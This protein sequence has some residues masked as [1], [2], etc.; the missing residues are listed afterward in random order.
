MCGPRRTGKPRSFYPLRLLPL[1]PFTLLFVTCFNPSPRLPLRPYLFIY[2]SFLPFSIFRPSVRN[3][4][5]FPAAHETVFSKCRL[6]TVHNDVKSICLIT[7]QELHIGFKFGHSSVIL[8]EETKYTPSHVH[9][10]IIRQLSVRGHDVR[11]YE[12]ISNG[13]MNCNGRPILPPLPH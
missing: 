12:I 3:Q 6:E 2:L 10:K 11:R 8:A 9:D 13:E 5:N 1:F 4:F 7:F